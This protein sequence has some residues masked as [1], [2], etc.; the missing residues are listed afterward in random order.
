MIE[1]HQKMLK[2][3]RRVENLINDA[4]MEVKVEI[5]SDEEEDFGIIPPLPHTH[6]HLTLLRIRMQRQTVR[7]SIFLLEGLLRLCGKCIHGHYF[8]KKE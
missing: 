8:F 5:I 6:T 3:Y 4:K 7:P 1:N 2:M